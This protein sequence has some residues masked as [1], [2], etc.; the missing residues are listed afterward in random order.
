MVLGCKLKVPA[1]MQKETFGVFLKLHGCIQLSLQGETGALVSN[2]KLRPIHVRASNKRDLRYEQ[3]LLVA[4]LNNNL[5]KSLLFPKSGQWENTWF[6][7]ETL[8]LSSEASLWFGLLWMI[9]KVSL[10]GTRGK[11]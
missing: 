7:V 1:N 6:L 10:C 8:D 3:K 5:C 4:K 11:T 9:V 2:T